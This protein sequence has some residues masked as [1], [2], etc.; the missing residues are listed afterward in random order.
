[1]PAYEKLTQAE[2]IARAPV[3]NPQIKP[4]NPIDQDDAHFVLN[5]IES[6]VRGRIQTSGFLAGGLHGGQIVQRLEEEWASIFHTKYAVSFNSGTSAL[7]A[8]CSAVGIGRHSSVLVPALSMSA[9]AVAPAFLGAH[10][11]WADISPDTFCI[12]QVNDLDTA[13]VN[14]VMV[15]SLFGMP[16]NLQHL[17]ELCDRRSWALIEDACQAPFATFD[18]R[19]VGTW[20]DVGV[21]SL[22]VHKHMQTGEGGIAVTNRGG[23]A[24]KLRLF[25]NHGECHTALSSN[26]SQLG[27]NLRMTELTAAHALAQL[28]KG[29]NAVERTRSLAR[30]L[31]GM[32]SETGVV[33]E[34]ARY[35]YESGHGLSI[36]H[37]AYYVYPIIFFKHR[38]WWVKNLQAEGVPIRAGYVEPLYHLSALAPHNITI[39]CPN[40]E[41]A[42]RHLGVIELT[43]ID[44]TVEQ[45]AQIGKAFTKVLHVYVNS[46]G[47]N[48]V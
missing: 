38:D 12:E 9:T 8:A 25:R 45:L 32:L 31:D 36:R 41:W 22:N 26:P 43:A 15:T 11:R 5:A 40:A 39:R 27:L 30:A 2:A 13:D 20:G 35:L 42:H 46:H 1:M 33:P 10:L 19:Y 24:E 18:D 44:P 6:M 37:S 34:I 16:A 4:F 17:R 47:S 28:A 29:Q 21:F 3:V 48:P 7:L 23:I 14:A